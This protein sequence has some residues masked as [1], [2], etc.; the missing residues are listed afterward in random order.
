MPRVYHTCSYHVA[1]RNTR[2]QVE[3]PVT[4]MIT[5]LDLVEWQLEVYILSH[6]HLQ[7]HQ[8]K[9]FSDSGIGC[10]GKSTPTIA[11]SDTAGW[12]CIRGADIRREPSKQLPSRLRSSTVPLNAD[13]HTCFCSCSVYDASRSEQ[14]VHLIPSADGG[15][16]SGRR[17]V[18]ALGT[19]V[20]PGST[21]R[22]VLRSY[23]REAGRPRTRPH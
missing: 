9:C 10:G 23:D 15:H 11:V 6:P 19:R 12:S 3:H 8:L 14:F 16:I 18:A 4:E 22:R 7:C 20:R 13:A 21:D 5:G 17:A 1:L 2:L